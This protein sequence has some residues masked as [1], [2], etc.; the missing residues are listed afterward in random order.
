MKL[1]YGLLVMVS[2]VEGADGLGK[3]QFTIRARRGLP[4]LPLL[5]ITTS[6]FPTEK[7]F[8]YADEHALY[9]VAA[10]ESTQEIERMLRDKDTDPN[11]ADPTNGMT[12]LMYAAMHG[13]IAAVAPLVFDSR[14]DTSKVDHIGYNALMHAVV[15]CL[16]IEDLLDRYQA[17]IKVLVPV[18]NLD[19][20]AR[21]GQTVKEKAIALK[22]ESILALLP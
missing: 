20:V 16:R 3:Q 4:P 1:L 11:A 19:H 21:D 15:N 6:F 18:T 12:P 7:G 10:F 2:V 22:K 14:V 17:V 5:H 8:K 9:C 13:N